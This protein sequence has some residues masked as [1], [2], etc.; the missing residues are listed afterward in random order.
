M[1]VPRYATGLRHLAV[2]IYRLHCYSRLLPSLAE[3]GISARVLACIPALLYILVV[4]GC[5]TGLDGCINR[6]DE[7]VWRQRNVCDAFVIIFA[8]LVAQLTTSLPCLWPNSPQHHGE[9]IILRPL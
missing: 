2:L 9:D 8:L 3:R 4:S 1:A 7:I 5:I 6:T